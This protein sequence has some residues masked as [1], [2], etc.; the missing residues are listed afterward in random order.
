MSNL[1]I[2]TDHVKI[3]NG[4]LEIAS[5]LAKPAAEGPFPGVV[6]IKKYLG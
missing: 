3:S 1:E 6:V 5:Y 2:R 4:D